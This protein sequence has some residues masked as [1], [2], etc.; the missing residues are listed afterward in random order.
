MKLFLA[1][2]DDSGMIETIRNSNHPNFLSSYF[3]HRKKFNPKWVDW[4][5]KTKKGDWIMDS[6]LFTMMFGAG[7]GK[8]YKEEDLIEYTHKYI[9]DLKTIKYSHYVVEMDVHKIFGLE[10]L[11]RFRHIFKQKYD[12]EKTI[13]VWHI[14]EGEQGF[15]NLCKTYPYIAISIPELRIVLKG[16]NNLEQMTKKLIRLANKINPNIKIHLLGCTQQNLMEQKGYYSCDSTSWFSSA[17][18]GTASFFNGSKLQQIH[19]RSKQWENYIELKKDEFKKLREHIKDTD[20]YLNMFL[21]AKAYHYLNAYINNKYY[22]YEQ[23]KS[24]L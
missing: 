8:D 24:I 14:E 12:I 11:K 20:Y 3:C 18:Y 13:Y 9:N 1:G 21:G 23:I 22:N 6:G 10:S 4:Y 16:K 5:N 15:I 2:A 7:S 19:I 17:R